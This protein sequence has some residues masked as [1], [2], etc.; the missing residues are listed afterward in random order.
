MNNKVSLYQFLEVNEHLIYPQA[1]YIL[2]LIRIFS[3]NQIPRAQKQ[4][5]HRCQSTVSDHP[6]FVSCTQ[7][8]RLT[9]Q[10]HFFKSDTLTSGIIHGFL[11]TPI[12]NKIDSHIHLKHDPKIEEGDKINFKEIL[13]I[14]NLAKHSN[15]TL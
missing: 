12:T 6:L 3:K 10:H 4:C 14:L 15:T 7:K 2:R 5:W 1:K 13:L 11:T 8:V 9:N